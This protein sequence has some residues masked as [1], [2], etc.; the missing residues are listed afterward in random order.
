MLFFFR[1]KK[2]VVFDDENAEKEIV[3]NV[4]IWYAY[5]RFRDFL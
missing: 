4:K 2:K 1:R 5:M 3:V